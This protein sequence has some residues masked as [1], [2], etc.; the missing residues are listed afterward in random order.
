MADT[1]SHVSKLRRTLVIII[2]ATIPFY[3][4]GMIVLW[5]GDTARAQTTLTPMVSTIIITAT[6]QASVTPAPPTAYPTP[7]AT[8][9]PT[10]TPTH[11]PTATATFTL[12]PT[13]TNT[14]TETETP[15]AVLTD[16]IAAPTLE[17]PTALPGETLTP[18]S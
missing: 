7:T 16:T 17:L 5:V 3:L 8:T 18:G 10:K 1:V 14:P 2:L 12:T 15:T 13:I 11:T 4:L 6:P 9:T